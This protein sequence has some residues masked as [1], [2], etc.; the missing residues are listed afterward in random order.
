M[1]DGNLVSIIIPV[2]NAEK[3]IQKTI[4]SV[5]GQS[6]ENIEIILVDDGSKDNSG[7]LCDQLASQDIRIKVIHIDNKGVSNARNVGLLNALGEFVAFV[8]AD[9]L[10]DSDMISVFF[11]SMIDNSVDLVIAP[12]K[13][14]M[15]IS[16]SIVEC[17]M[18]YSGLYDKYEFTK[19]VISDYYFGYSRNKFMGSCWGKLFRRKI[20]KDKRIVFDTNLHYSEDNLFILS[21]FAV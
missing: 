18:N 11:K 10:I 20:L 21:I 4:I 8:D 19:S 7:V 6:Y 5:A 15:T 1:A 14:L 17:N 2:Y 13:R 9:D 12:F 16:N 3:T